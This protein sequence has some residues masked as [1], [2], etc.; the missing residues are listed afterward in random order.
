MGN[1]EVA[2]LDAFE[3]VGGVYTNDE[4]VFLILISSS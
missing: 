1:R 4:F 3:S 2:L